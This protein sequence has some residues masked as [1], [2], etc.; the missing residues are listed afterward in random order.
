MSLPTSRKQLCVTGFAIM[1]LAACSRDRATGS[2]APAP[3]LSQ[4]IRADH[5]SERTGSE[6]MLTRHVPGIGFVDRDGRYWKLVRATN[7]EVVLDR[8]PDMERWKAIVEGSPFRYWISKDGG[9]F[10]EGSLVDDDGTVVVELKTP[11]RIDN[12]QGVQQISGGPRPCALVTRGRLT[13]FAESLTYG[14]GMSL[15]GTRRSN[16]ITVVESGVQLVT[17]MGK[18]CFLKD[19]QIQ[20]VQVD[21]PDNATTATARLERIPIDD[22]DDFC[23]SGTSPDLTPNGCA[24]VGQELVCWGPPSDLPKDEPRSAHVQKGTFVVRRAFNQPLTQI[25]CDWTGVR[26]VTTDGELWSGDGPHPVLRKL[27]RFANVRDVSVIDGLIC[28]V[29]LGGGLSCYGLYK[30]TQWVGSGKHDD[31]RP[32]RIRS[33]AQAAA[34]PR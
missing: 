27:T 19:R 5:T 2:N 31:P 18:A 1:S 4:G 11:R 7:K 10:A 8:A 3:T 13:C 14:L 6:V 28:A 23:T 32:V 33:I 20:C 34:P 29:E 26:V 9:A 30:G 25:S 21:F 15:T 16:F 22:V 17:G 24:R 12:L